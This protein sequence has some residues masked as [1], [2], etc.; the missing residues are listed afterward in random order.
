MYYYEMYLTHQ[1]LLFFVIIVCYCYFNLLYYTVFILIFVGLFDLILQQKI[2][3]H[4]NILIL[5]TGGLQGKS[6]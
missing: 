6:N 3:P 5:H 1:F 4:S 2:P